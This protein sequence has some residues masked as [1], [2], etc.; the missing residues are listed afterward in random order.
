MVLAVYPVSSA[1]PSRDRYSG[2]SVEGAFGRWIAAGLELWEY[3][4]VV[5]HSKYA[6]VDDDWCLGGTFNANV[7]RVAFAIEVALVSLQP[8]DASAA[9]D[10]MLRDLAQSRIVDGARLRRV[11]L[12]RVIAGHIARA[13]MSLANLIFHRRPVLL[14]PKGP[15]ERKHR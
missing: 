15:E 9:A 7:A 6:V 8:S 2:C 4:G 14:P 10:Q 5:M 3:Q 13:V 1:A 11:G 12:V